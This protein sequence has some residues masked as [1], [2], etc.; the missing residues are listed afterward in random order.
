MK[1]LFII[2][3]IDISF[4]GP[5]HSIINLC[6]ALAQS[7]SDITLFTTC[8][9]GEVPELT[10]KGFDVRYFSSSWPKKNFNSKGMIDEIQRVGRSYDII[11]VSSLWNFTSAR[12]MKVASKIGVP[13]VLTVHGMLSAWE[14]GFR[15]LHKEIFY[16]AVHEKQIKRARLLRY[17][18][19]QEK[20]DSS[21]NVGVINHAIVSN[22]I[23]PEEFEG[24]DATRFLDQYNLRH[25]SLVLFLG[26][27]DG[28]KRLDLQCEAF[29]SLAP[30]FPALSWA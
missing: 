2:P 29:K 13:F 26:R 12:A 18:T 30:R 4:G 22:G 17:L 8:P 15:S 16:K 21:Q 23:W 19:E 5:S 11:H 14:R 20:D 6:Y 9:T 24:L 1:I 27:L 28:I 25:S 3:S 7:G 10:G